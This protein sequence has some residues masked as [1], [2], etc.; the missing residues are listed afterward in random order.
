MPNP[1]DEE[2]FQGGAAEDRPLTLAQAILAPVDSLLKAQV[3]ATRSFLN[4]LLQLGTRHQP[5]GED[6]KPNEKTNDLPYEMKF[7]IGQDTADG[8]KNVEI[9]IP[10]LA[11]VPLKPLTISRARFKFALSIK[12]V[13]KFRQIST[14]RG[15]VAKTDG[16]GYDDYSRPWNLVRNPV[17]LVGTVAPRKPN[18]GSVEQS[19]IID[20]EVE[21]D[22]API[23][24]PLDKL[25][26]TLG[27]GA[28]SPTVKPAV[29]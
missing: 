10:T 15:Q 7:E 20:I 3:H 9:R 23:P 6:G 21:V 11:L 16:N 5:V 12:S 29:D 2:N 25:L 27:N 18:E 8:R 4:L 26:A 19:A 14:E 22:T 24:E 28:I 17:S 13:E 1:E